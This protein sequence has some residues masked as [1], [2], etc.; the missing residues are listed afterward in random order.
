MKV[1][2]LRRIFFFLLVFLSFSLRYLWFRTA[3]CNNI[4]PSTYQ[5][6]NP[7]NYITICIKSKTGASSD[8]IQKPL[9][10][11]GSF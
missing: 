4:F 5:E 7:T 10:G 1:Q 2:F 3:V 9:C 8:W 11:M 6:N